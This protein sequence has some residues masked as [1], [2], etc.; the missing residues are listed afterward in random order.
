V[1]G[2]TG[3]L[4]FSPRLTG[5]TVCE[6]VCDAPI[7]LL[8]LRLHAALHL[9]GRDVLDVRVDRPRVAPLVNNGGDTVTVELVRWLA[10][11]LPARRQRLLVRRVYWLT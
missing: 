9:R 5:A 2:E 7:S 8:L 6:S 11:R 3:G 1:E 10:L 4:R